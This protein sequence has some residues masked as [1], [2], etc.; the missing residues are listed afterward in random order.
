MLHDEILR[1]AD[2]MVE[3]KRLAVLDHLRQVYD[4]VTSLQRRVAG[5]EFVNELGEMQSITTILDC[6]IASL[7][8]AVKMHRMIR[9]TIE[10][11]ND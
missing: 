7:A 3:S 9:E 11:A 2:E 4:V 1:Q 8:T 6:K 5:S 10:C